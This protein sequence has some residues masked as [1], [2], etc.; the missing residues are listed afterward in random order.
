MPTPA[1]S[2]RYTHYLLSASHG[3]GVLVLLSG[4]ACPGLFYVTP[5]IDGI[6]SRIR[7]PGGIL[8]SIQCRAIADIADQYGGGYIDVT[9]RANLQVREIRTQ[10]N[11]EVLKYLQDL[12][13]G[14]PNTECRP[15]PQYY[16]QPNC[17]HRS[18]R[19]NRYSS[20]CPRLG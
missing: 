13:L 12:G 18:S 8:N 20:F 6:L 15:H 4:I 16:D 17:W 7:V 1:V 10:I 2:S 9:N 3:E 5:A 11:A 14:S 19:I